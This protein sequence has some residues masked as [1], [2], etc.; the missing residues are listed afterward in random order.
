MTFG[1]LITITVGL[2]AA[3]GLVGIFGGAVRARQSGGK[4]SFRIGSIAMT[5]AGLVLMLA[6]ITGV[7]EGDKIFGGLMMLIFGT[8]VAL[9][10]ARTLAGDRAARSSI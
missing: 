8:S 4:R 1:S 2:L 7:V 10:S 9:P 3:I 6:S 5:L